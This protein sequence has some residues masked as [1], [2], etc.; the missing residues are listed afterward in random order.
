MDYCIKN[1]KNVF[2]KLDNNGSPVTCVESVKGIFEYS[3][4]RNILDNIPKT[5]KRLNF[6]L[7][8]IPDIPQKEKKVIH[9]EVDRQ[10]SEDITRWVDKF[11]ICADIFNEAKERENEL[12]LELDKSDKE[13]LDLLHI[14][15]IEKP[16]DMF[17]GWKLYKGI[18][19]NRER[20]RNIK[21]ELLIVDNVLKEINPACMQRDRVQKA[22]D[23]LFGRKYTFRIVEEGE[24]NAVL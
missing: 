11:G 7:E 17:S 18:R 3:K 10:L 1:S 15:E 5:L 16:K 8:A 21:D 12:I 4:A 9:K 6:K 24:E 14:I 2:I 20:R 22:I 23:G 19:D 13:L